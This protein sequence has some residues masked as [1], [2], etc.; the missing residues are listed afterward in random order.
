MKVALYWG[1]YGMFVVAMDDDDYQG[2]DEA[3]SSFNFIK[4]VQ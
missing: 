4:W 2:M 1:I 3:E